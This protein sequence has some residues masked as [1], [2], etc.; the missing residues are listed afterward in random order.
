MQTNTESHDQH[1]HLLTR[2]AVIPTPLRLDADH[3]RTG[4]G[5]TM[6]FL[7]S[8]FYPH[9][10]LTQPVNRIVAFK[11]ITQPRALLK[12]DRQPKPWAWHGTQTSVVAAGNGHL[13][14]GTY[15]GLACNA[16][17]VL[18]KVGDH[19][20]ITE[21][22]I[23]RGLRWVIENK[24]RYNIQ[25]VS[26][27]LGGDNDVP[28]Q[29]NVV[30]QLAEEAVSD[31][32]TLVVAA[33]NS[34]C[35]D[36]HNTVPPANSPSVI[37][38][39]GY[40]DQ[41][42]LGRGDLDLYCSSYGITA[43]GVVKPEIL[44][45]AMWV[46]APILPNTAIYKKAIILSQLVSAPDDRLTGVADRFWP[47]A[48]E[49]HS[50]AQGQPGV[51]REAVEALLHEHKI[52][53]T[54]YQHV[55]GTS[56][57]APIVASIVAQMLEANPRLTPLM[58]KQILINTADRIQAAPLL[59]Q[60]YGVVN[61]RRAVLEAS[62]EQHV[63]NHRN[64][65][66]PRIEAGKLVFFYHADH[67]QRVSMAGDFNGWDPVRTPFVRGEDGIWRAEIETPSPGRYGYKFVVDGD[68]WVEDPVNGFKQ[69]DSFGGLN[70]VLSIA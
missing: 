43:D 23:A 47:D 5:V 30:D 2:F 27:S 28:Y 20:K 3:E 37:T 39:G 40:D 56:F 6:A 29:Q 18:V 7:D 55:D 65:T 21:D 19:G 68:R 67:A 36:D 61:A 48:A 53:A 32:L 8:G 42:K 66:P 70:S 15:R 35:T 51:V 45:P 22:N 34:G 26:I 38:V 49:L 14:D 41:N 52:V 62:R 10:D 33:G 11:D 13:S 44:A 4:K 12:A 63:L 59:R 1:Q 9:T 46:A 16:D 64:L 69:P 57:A 24:E 54:H 58:T 60:G 25:V 31:G 50:I 17:V